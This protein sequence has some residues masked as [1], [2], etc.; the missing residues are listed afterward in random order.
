MKSMAVILIILSI[1]LVSFH[2]GESLTKV[3]QEDN[4]SPP[5]SR[6][7]C[8]QPECEHHCAL[9]HPKTK[10]WGKCK[11]NDDRFVCECC[12]LCD[13]HSLEAPSYN[14]RKLSYAPSY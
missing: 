5:L 10:A 7:L 3:C 11:F 1:V 9:R 14:A 4:P 8:N 6:S 13:H 2:G 12:Y